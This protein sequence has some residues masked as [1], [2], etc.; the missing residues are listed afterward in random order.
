M[1]FG[2][3]SRAVPFQLKRRSKM[4]TTVCSALLATSV[5]VGMLAAQPLFSAEDKAKTAAKSDKKGDNVDKDKRAASTPQ[6]EAVG[7]AAVA[8]QLVVYGDKNKD[9]MALIMAARILN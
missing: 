9:A 7:M 3:D 4:K 8:D 1:P 6:A 5:A 2:G